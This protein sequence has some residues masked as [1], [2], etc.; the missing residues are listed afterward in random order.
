[1]AGLYLTLATAIER[2]DDP[3]LL[4]PSFGTA[5]EL[6]RVLDEITAASRSG[7]RRSLGPAAG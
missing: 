7:G 6:H 5:V 3:A 4:E 1:V 2:G